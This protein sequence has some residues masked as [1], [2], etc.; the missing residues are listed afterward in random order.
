LA[1]LSAVTSTEITD[2]TITAADLAVGAV[3]LTTTDVTGILPIALGGTNSSATPTNGGV[4]YGTGTAHAYTAAGT[5]GQLL[6]SNGAAAPTWINAPATVTASNGLTKTVNDIALGGTLTTAT[7]IAMGTNNLTFT[8]TG[9]FNFQAGSLGVGVA[10]T[11]KFHVFQNVS[12]VTPE[13]VI[14]NGNGTGDGSLRLSGGATHYT[15][16]SDASANAF[17]ISNN[18]T[19]LGTNDRL[20]ISSTGNVGLGVTPLSKLDVEGGVAIGSTYSGTTVAP[21]NGLIV[22]GNVGIGTN[23]PSTNKVFVSI[24]STDA[25][26]PISLRVD[27]NYTGASAKYGIDVNVDGAGSGIKYGI[28]STIVGLAGDASTNYGYQVAMTPNGTGPVY[29]LYS[30]ISSVGTGIRY[31]IRNNVYGLNTNTSDIYGNYNYVNHAGSGDSYAFYGNNISAGSGLNYGAYMINET[32]NYFSGRIG[33]GTATPGAKLHLKMSGTGITDGF[34]IE[35]SAATGEDWYM[36][37]NASNNLIFRDDGFDFFILQNGT[38]RVGIARTPA[39]NDLEVEGTAS[40]TASGSWAANSDKRI[41]SDILDIT[42]SIDLIKKLR[43]V[44]FKYTQEYMKLHPSLQD[45][46]YYNFIAQEFQQVFPDAVK[47]SGEKLPD[48]SDEILQ[49]DTYDA[50][51]TTIKAVQEL[52]V[53]IEKLETENRLLREQVSQLDALGILQEIKQLRAELNVLKAQNPNTPGKK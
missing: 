15:I 34:R 22:E 28:S 7:S 17:V 44:K 35:T 40:K 24:P 10:P 3:D 50:Q 16:G 31:G 18:S 14:E 12:G 37:M 19:G 52:I 49:I 38:G 42:N 4:G 43:P 32:Y 48:G 20:I 2:A 13:A 21:T 46:Y 5:T 47:S 30:N 26:N 27:N 8:G 23:A 36:Y 51:I 25:I 11:S 1:T 45:K 39:A 33:V 9:N 29:G 53:K 41:K 6:Q